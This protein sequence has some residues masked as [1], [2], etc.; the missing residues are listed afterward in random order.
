L[1]ERG[2]RVI[3]VN[4][5]QANTQH[6]RS[7]LNAPTVTQ[8]ILLNWGT[9]S[10]GEGG[11]LGTV[12]ANPSN[13]AQPFLIPDANQ[14]N[15]VTCEIWLPGPALVMNGAYI[16]D[17]KYIMEVSENLW[18]VDANG[19][20]IEQ[21]IQYG[22]L[23]MWG[24]TPISG[25]LHGNS[26]WGSNSNYPYNQLPPGS[27]NKKSNTGRAITGPVYVCGFRATI[28]VDHATASLTLGPQILYFQ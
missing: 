26:Y 15:N 23:P 10:F 21:V 16:Y 17:P 20:D 6:V 4:D 28:T 3:S 5:L 25:T 13:H 19:V 7:A 9:T 2:L 18:T 11:S 14:V 27:W 24:V 22:D 8:L 1:L 12:W